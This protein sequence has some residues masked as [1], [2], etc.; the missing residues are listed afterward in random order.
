MVSNAAQA[1]EFLYS[2]LLGLM[3]GTVYVLTHWFGRLKLVMDLVFSLF[4][5]SAATVFFL[6]VCGGLVRG[7]QLTAVILGMLLVVQAWHCAGIRRK[8]GQ[9]KSKAKKT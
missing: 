6:T 7:Y 4:A 2:L 5:L 8:N 9:K 1:A 3:L